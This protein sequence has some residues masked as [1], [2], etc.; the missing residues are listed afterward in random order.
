M[1][2]IIKELGAFEH[3]TVHRL[4][5]DYNDVETS[6][7]FWFLNFLKPSES[8][9]YSYN[10]ILLKS[11]QETI[12]YEMLNI[13]YINVSSN[14]EVLWII[15]M[16]T[17]TKWMYYYVVNSCVESQNDSCNF[18]KLLLHALNENIGYT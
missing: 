10:K 6:F 1:G 8:L 9:L 3:I 12:K 16:V 15:I 7:E 5:E 11:Y 4:D 14:Y 18:S 13:F 2:F 17:C